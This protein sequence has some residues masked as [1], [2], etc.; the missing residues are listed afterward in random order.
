M[1]VTEWYGGSGQRPHGM[2]ITEYRKIPCHVDVSKISDAFEASHILVRNMH[3]RDNGF[4]GITNP[5]EVVA[6]ILDR[7]PAKELREFEL[8]WDKYL[9]Q[10]PDLTVA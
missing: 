2:T 1:N 10:Y 3:W 7:I 8:Y 9:R 4:A 6:Y 5:S